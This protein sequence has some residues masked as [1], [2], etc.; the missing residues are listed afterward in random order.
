MLKVVFRKMLSKR[1]MMLALLI[2]NILLV[3]IAAGNAMYSK[4]VLQRTLTREF[5][6][7]M[8]ET[9][10]YPATVVLTVGRTKSQLPNY[11][12]LKALHQTIEERFGAP[13]L[14]TVEH[15]MLSRS[16]VEPKQKRGDFSRTDITIGCLTELTL[17]ARI[18]GEPYR[19]TP[20]ENGVVD[21]LI[22]AATQEKLKLVVGDE[23]TI[24]KITTPNGEPLVV[25]ITG[26]FDR[27]DTQD[28]YWL[29]LPEEVTAEFFISPILFKQY[30]TSDSIEGMSRGVGAQ[31]CTLLDYTKIDSDKIDQ[32][33]AAAG[34]LNA[35]IGS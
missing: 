25:R 32:L 22:T 2:G 14:Q 3:G 35:E 12:K 6:Q 30:Y 23:L 20:D 15:L 29:E 4:A 27:A 10:Q 19:D 5:Q 7:T 16:A 26:V 31:W 28:P 1:W 18:A 17:H 21:A 11:F 34:K 9:Q 8:E 13:A 33:M 24:K